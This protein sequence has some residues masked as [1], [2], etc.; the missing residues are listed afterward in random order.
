MTIDCLEINVVG[1][2]CFP[3]FHLN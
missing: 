2:S 1:K 3:R